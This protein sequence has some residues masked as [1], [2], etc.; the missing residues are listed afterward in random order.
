MRDFARLAG[1]CLLLF[2]WIAAGG[3]VATAANFSESVE[4]G[5]VFVGT[6]VVFQLDDLMLLPRGHLLAGGSLASAIVTTAPTG[7]FGLTFTTN[8][9]LFFPSFLPSGPG[10]FFGTADVIWTAN[11][12]P[13]GLTDID[14]AFSFHG[15]G[16]AIPEPSAL[17]FF[18]LAG[19]GTL[20][21]RRVFGG[22]GGLGGS[23]LSSPDVSSS[24]PG[25]VTAAI[26]SVIEG[27]EALCRFPVAPQPQSDRRAPPSVDQHMA[28]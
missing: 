20:L 24:R 26:Y 19:L 22:A 25:G 5:S 14:V 1:T 9:L 6:E 13:L 21:T 8:P 3:G 4:F 11:V 2:G 16:V 27:I 10:E 18:G 12:P 23:H 15:I 7:T 28:E 17:A